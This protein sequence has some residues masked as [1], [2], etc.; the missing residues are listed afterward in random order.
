MVDDFEG[1]EISGLYDIASE[2]DAEKY[3][4][5]ITMGGNFDDGRGNA[6][7][8]VGY[9]DQDPVLQGDRSFGLFNV[10][11][12]SGNAGGSSNSVPSNIVFVGPNANVIGQINN[13][14][15][16]IVP[17]VNSAAG[18]FN[19][20]PFNLFQTPIERFNIFGSARYEVSEAVD[21]MEFYSHSSRY[22]EKYENLINFIINDDCFLLLVKY[23]FCSKKV[24]ANSM[25][26]IT[27]LF[28]SDRK[29][30]KE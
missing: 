12:F 19:F 14:G 2:G 28:T 1:V 25:V 5:D 27:I 21:F 17:G 3:N 8:S 30:E 9:L 24:Y 4:M 29:S 20:N 10:S 6:L 16:D 18:P 13:A 11:S 7:L 23:D 22:W 26:S 15:T